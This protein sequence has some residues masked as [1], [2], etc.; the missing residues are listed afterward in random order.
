MTYLIDSRYGCQS[1]LRICTYRHRQRIKYQILFC[2]TIVC[3]P[4]DD[5]LRYLYSSFG[6]IRNTALVQSQTYDKSSVLC[7]QRKYLI[8]DLLFSVYGVYHSFAVVCTQ[9]RLHSDR[10][11]SIELQRQ[12]RHRLE[13]LNHIKQHSRL[14]YLRQ[15]DIYIE[16]VRTGIL[17]V[18][19]FAQYIVDVVLTESLLKSLLAGRIYPLTDKYRRSTKLHYFCV[20]GYKRPVFISNR[21]RRNILSC[22][23]DSLYIVRRRAA[24]PSC[25]PDSILHEMTY[26]LGKLVRINIINRLAVY[27]L[28]QTCIRLEEHRHGSVGQ[29]LIY[30]AL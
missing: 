11:R 7:N 19:S 17:L 28:W 12:I 2:D 3:C 10:I 5:L 6:I 27:T 26:R 4:L 21:N 1:R 9:S 23:A 18:Q 15:T 16:D 14:I 24:A 29:V 8:H 22:L 30:H 13:F 25:D 20:R